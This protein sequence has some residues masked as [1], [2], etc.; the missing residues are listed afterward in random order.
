[1]IAGFNPEMI[2]DLAGAHTVIRALLNLV[3]ELQAENQA[4]RKQVGE[5]RDEVNWLKGEQG[6]PQIKPDKKKGVSSQ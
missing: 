5:L 2:Q 4:L 3:E 6:R 1:M